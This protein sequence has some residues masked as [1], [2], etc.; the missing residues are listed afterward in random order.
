MS[1]RL[2][3]IWRWYEWPLREGRDLGVDLVAQRKSGEYIAIQCKCYDESRTVGKKEIKD[4]LVAS[5]DDIFALRWLV[6]TCRLGVN[7]KSLLL[8]ARPEGRWIDFEEYWDVEVDES[9]EERLLQ[10]PWPSQREAI[11]KVIRGFARRDR[12]SLIMACGTG[13]TFT[14]LRIAE[15]LV[16]DGENI[17]FVAPSIALVS[18]AR[19][20]WLRQRKRTLRGLVVCS[21]KTAGREDETREIQNLECPVSTKS[22]EI[23]EKLSKG[24]SGEIMV[25]FCTYQSL[26]R[27]VEAQRE[28]HAPPFALAIADE[29]HRTTGILREIDEND[30]VDFQEFHKDDRLH[31][32]KRLYMT[33]TPRVYTEKSIKQLEKRK[34][35]VFDMKNSEI[36][37][38]EF[39]RLS[40]KDAVKC[41]ILSDYRVILLGLRE[42]SVTG[43]LRQQLTSID[44]SKFKP[45][46]GDM[47]RVLGVLKAVKGVIRG[48]SEETP[49]L[50]RRMIAFANTIA[51][52]KWYAKALVKIQSKFHSPAL[53]ES[54]RENIVVVAEH[55][56]ASDDA[57]ER[58]EARDRLENPNKDYTCDDP[59][60]IGKTKCRVIS[61][62]RLF[63]EGVDVPS[64]DAVTFLDPRNSQVDVVQA[65]G[66]VMRKSK[67]K[68]F[69]YIV[70]PVVLPPGCDA[71]KEL[72]A[73]TDGYKTI[74]KVLRALQSH[75]SRLFETQA[76]LIQVHN[77]P[78]E[79]A[80]PADEFLSSEDPLQGLLELEEAEEGIYAHLAS[81]A[82]LGRRGEDAA[83]QIAGVVRSMSGVLESEGQEEV[84]ARV[85]DLVIEKKGGAKEVCTIGGLMLC[86][87]CLL[88]KRLRDSLETIPSLDDI[89]NED[90]P[91]K[92]LGDAWEVI[93]RKDYAPVFDPAL[94]LLRELGRSKKIDEAIV[95]MIGEANDLAD[96]LSEL[97]YDHAGPLYH[98]ILG[99]AKSDGAFYTN[100][101]S[102]ILLARLAFSEGL[103][104]W[105]DEEAV[106]GLRVMDPACGTGTLLMAAL[107]TIKGRV[108]KTGDG[109]SET[110][111]QRLVEDVLCGLDINQHGVQLAACNLTLGAPTVD[112]KRMNLAA[113]PHG[114]QSDERR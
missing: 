28:F 38:R 58:R 3:G 47:T 16:K 84:M 93:L 52:S 37:G 46:I 51:R 99:S 44:I 105:G 91:L 103:I 109:T 95:Y 1:L 101:V 19:R 102:A 12:G 64:L 36:Y 73:R 72:E 54:E 30:T 11:E 90:D 7:A 70:V 43:D 48:N 50:L 100:N 13:K 83:A 23:A 69:G 75:D 10:D 53:K 33:A 40:F 89:R 61:N 6:S 2:K 31:A 81:M 59:E 42:T 32:R 14:S 66:R 94:R 62:V 80:L 97:G 49:D 5:E 76:R 92:A 39:Y 55:L 56:D 78:S 26:R 98:R 18:Q 77:P 85:L 27:V 106:G 34:I 20:V 82:G 111:H 107:Q 9:V 41:K 15:E 68:K 104:D 29:A 79:K 87:A 114:P 74:G 57:R 4:F 112:Y 22:E 25:V 60:N 67:G 108:Q 35:E 45:D 71:I 24:D 65:V 21:D 110:L 86:N 8:K 96:S 88:Q 17:L 113:M 63:S